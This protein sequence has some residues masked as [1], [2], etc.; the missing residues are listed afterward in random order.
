MAS[1][2]YSWR[3]LTPPAGW[4]VDA[5]TAGDQVEP[6]IT[7]SASAFGYFAAWTT[8]GTDIDGRLLGNVAVPF[9]GEFV[10]S[11]PAANDQNEPSVATLANGNYVVSYTDLGLAATGDLVGRIF[12]A[13]GSPIVSFT[14]V[15]TGLPEFEP[16]VAALAGGGFVVSYTAAVGNDDDIRAR[17]FNAD[18]SVHV[19]TVL[20]NDNTRSTT[21]S[22]TV[23]LAGGGFV[24]AWTEQPQPVLQQPPGPSE[25]R[26]GL[27]D[28]VGNPLKGDH[29]TGVLIDNFLNINRDIHIAALPDGGFVVAYE[30]DGWSDGG[31]TDITARVFNADG[32][33]RSGFILVDTGAPAGGQIAPSVTAMGDGFVVGW[34]AASNQVEYAQAYDAGGNPIGGN[35]AIMSSVTRSVVAAHDNGQLAVLAASS[36]TDGSS[37]SMRAAAALLVRKIDGDASSEIIHAVGDSLTEDIDAKGGDDTIVLAPKSPSFTDQ[38]DGGDGDD[39]VVFSHSLGEYLIRGTFGSS[40]APIGPDGS[41]SI[42]NVEHLQFTDGTITL[43]SGLID[44]AFYL[45]NNLDVFHANIDPAAHFNQWGWHEGRDPDAYFSVRDYLDANPDLKAAG[46]NPLAQYDQAGWKQGRDPGPNFDTKLYLIHNPDVAAAG[47]DPLAHFL[48]FGAAEGRQAYPAIGQT[49]VNGF[50]AEYYLFHNA[51]VAAAGVDPYQHYLT[52]GWHEGRNPNAWFDTAGYLAHYQD[53]AAAN[54]DPLTHYEQFGWKDG[55]DPS[56][57]FDTL[58]YLA[59]NP[60]VAAAH[61]DPLDHY[62]QSG[63]YEGRAVVD[64]GHWH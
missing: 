45:V 29:T 16:S 27:F 34:I 58:G 17:I 38:I 19:S 60:D 15:A 54:I 28:A 9:S 4:L 43:H 59:A 55:R 56:A 53:V 12:G 5:Q 63:I 36:L 51:D 3:I 13:N 23:G 39:T 30:D 10:V 61:I 40:I 14:V 2:S 21:H 44:Y 46:V 20:V 41:L 33:T 8:T 64:D 22:A 6:A 11:N 24:T 49:I 31:T 52:V 57:H 48:Q 47:I 37:N 62:M 1:T 35:A 42:H 26:F 18:G 7:A 25:A 50:D 32:T